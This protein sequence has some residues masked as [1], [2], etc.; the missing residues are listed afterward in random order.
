MKPVF[1]MLGA[2]VLSIGW[3]T[4]AQATFGCDVMPLPAGFIELHEAPDATSPIIVMVPV[5]ANLS[6]M[7]D[8][9]GIKGIWL[10]VAYSTDP[11]TFWGE[12]QIGWVVSDQLGN[13]G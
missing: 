4:T 10:R 13:C 1:K 7:G 12:G 2:T 5:G 3:A 6:D 8:A 11:A 9:G